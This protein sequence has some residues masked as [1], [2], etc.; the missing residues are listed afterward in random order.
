MLNGLSNCLACARSGETR[1][2]ASLARA[3]QAHMR[4]DSRRAPSHQSAQ[5]ASSGSVLRPQNCE[6]GDFSSCGRG[7]E[8]PRPWMAAQ[9]KWPCTKLRR[10]RHFARLPCI[11]EHAIRRCRAAHRPSSAS[12][13]F[14]IRCRH[15]NDSKFRTLFLI[16]RNLYDSEPHRVGTYEVGLKLRGTDDVEQSHFWESNY[17]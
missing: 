2:R 8:A 11:P 3:I 13:R 1:T 7:R 9:Y 15:P 17:L 14:R 16:L 6:P 5:H 12:R 10:H 4:M